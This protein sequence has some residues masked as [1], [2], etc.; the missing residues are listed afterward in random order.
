MRSTLPFLLVIASLGPGAPVCSAQAEDQG[1]FRFVYDND[2]FNATDRY[3]TQGIRLELSAPFVARS[4]FRHVLVGLG[5]EGQERHVLFAQQECFTPGSIRRDTIL[6]TDRPFAAA[7]Y[8]GERK[9]STDVAKKRMLSTSIT[10]GVLGPCAICAEEQVGIHRALD[11]IAPLGWQF[12]VANDVILNYS[13]ELD[14][15]LYRNS[16]AEL[17]GGVGGNLGTYR[18]NV[19][20]HSRLDLGLFNSSFDAIPSAE[21]GFQLIAFLDGGMRMIGYDATLQGGL[22]DH[23]SPHTLPAEAVERVVLRGEGGVRLRYHHL[24]LLYSKTFITREF[25]GGADHGWGSCV[26]TVLF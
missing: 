11:N 4:P 1:Y 8:L 10:L 21:P 7:M 25:E 23:K 9:I 17:S 19:G 5:E 18:T 14:Q 26:I 2:F 13:M 20:V 3:Y 15:R 6:R 22:F 12:Q 24:A 16:F